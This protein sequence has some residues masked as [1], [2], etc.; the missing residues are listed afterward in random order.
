[1]AAQLG[2]D[3]PGVTRKTQQLERLGL[4]TR[5]RDAADART[6]WVQLTPDGRQVLCRFLAARRQSL[7]QL[8]A[9]WPAADRGKL[10][11]LLTRFTSD[12]QNRL[13]ELNL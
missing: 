7:A 1:M 3:T 11:R 6:S 12:I 2:I 10:A 5:C 8:L 9:A 4:V 13:D